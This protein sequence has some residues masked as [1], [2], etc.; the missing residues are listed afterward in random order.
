MY[1]VVCKFARAVVRSKDTQKQLVRTSLINI[2]GYDKY[3]KGY[4]QYINGYDKYMKGY[5]QYINAYGKYPKD[6]LENIF[7][8]MPKKYLQS[9]W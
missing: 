7:T 2:L 9:H 3:M 6:F 5:D 8:A 4:D 1:D